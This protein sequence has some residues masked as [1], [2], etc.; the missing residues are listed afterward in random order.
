MDDILRVGSDD[1]LYKLREEK[2]VRAEAI[3]TW[4]A[5]AHG[6]SIGDNDHIHTLVSEAEAEIIRLRL[7][8]N[9]DKSRRIG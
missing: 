8:L 3:R 7:L 6:G 9:T 2:R 5:N 4:R 1:I